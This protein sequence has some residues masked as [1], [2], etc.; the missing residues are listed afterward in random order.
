MRISFIRLKLAFPATLRTIFNS[1]PASS[2]ALAVERI[3]DKGRHVSSTNLTLPYCS[4]APGWYR[5]TTVG[6]LWRVPWLT[7]VQLILTLLLTTILFHFIPHI[8]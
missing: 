8:A 1:I 2:D 3:T 4:P 7:K 5:L 6:Y